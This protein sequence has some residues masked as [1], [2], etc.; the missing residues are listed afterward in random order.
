MF[1]IKKVF[2][3]YR[4]NVLKYRNLLL[5]QAELGNDI[6]DLKKSIREHERDLRMEYRASVGGVLKDPLTGRSNADYAADVLNNILAKDE[7]LA[8]LRD[9]LVKVQSN[10]AIVDAEVEALEAELKL[11]RDRVEVII[12]VIQV[13]AEFYPERVSEWVNNE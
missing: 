7:T 4:G 5:K 3:E 9:S 1:D 13:W 12:P 6:A 2:E 11:S 8:S 10:K